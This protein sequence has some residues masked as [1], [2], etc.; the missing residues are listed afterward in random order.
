MYKQWYIDKWTNQLQ[1][2]NAI[3]KAC[4]YGTVQHKKKKQPE[5]WVTFH[6]P[7]LELTV[8]NAQKNEDTR[9]NNHSYK[10][11]IAQWNRKYDVS[12]DAFYFNG[13]NRLSA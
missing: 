12:N 8:R 13:S 10:E 4:K 9:N 5:D 1:H 6:Q 3:S 7:D 11:H 2:V